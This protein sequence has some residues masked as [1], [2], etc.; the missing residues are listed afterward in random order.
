MVVIGR[1]WTVAANLNYDWVVSGPDQGAPATLQLAIKAAY[2]LDKETSV[3]IETYNGLGDTRT[4][5]YAH[6][7]GYWIFGMPVAWLLCFHYAWGVSGIWVG[8][9]TALIMIGLILI[10]VWRRTQ[11]E[12]AL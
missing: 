3:G 8:L 11:R 6:L 4:P 10:F 5:A 9:T 7:I 12:H 2:A 1:P